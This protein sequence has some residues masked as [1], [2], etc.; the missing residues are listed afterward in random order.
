NPAPCRIP[1]EFMQHNILWGTDIQGPSYLWNLEGHVPAHVLTGKWRILWHEDINFEH[2]RQV[3]DIKAA[4]APDSVL[5]HLDI[6]VV[7]WQQESSQ[8]LSMLWPQ[9]GHE[10][11][12]QG[13]PSHACDTAGDRPTPIIRP[14]QASEH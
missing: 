11:S 8:W 2:G 6:R 4:R 10:I 9:Y 7:V 12:V 13:S 5:H 1:Q 14:L 3:D